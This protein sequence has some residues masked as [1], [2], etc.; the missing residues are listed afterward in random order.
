MA[1]IDDKIEYKFDIA[2]QHLLESKFIDYDY[3]IDKVASWETEL[4]LNKETFNNTTTSGYIIAKNAFSES[5]TE[6]VN[7]SVLLNSISTLKHSDKCHEYFNDEDERRLHNFQENYVDGSSR[8]LVRWK[9]EQSL[10]TYDDGFGLMVI[11]TIGLIYPSGD[12]SGFFPKYPSSLPDYSGITGEKFFARTFGNN[13]DDKI[14]KFGGIF[15]ITGLTKEQFLNCNLSIIIS[16]D[17]SRWYSLKHVRGENV[18]VSTGEGNSSIS[19]TGVLTKLE[20]NDGKLQVSWM[21]PG[22]TS[23]INL[24]YFKLGMNKNL[25]H[26][27]FCIKSISLLNSDGTEEW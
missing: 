20:E 3:S 19:A 5:N 27:K 13:N 26:E 9:S 14:R 12:W 22:T 7:V 24:L 16:P 1:A 6:I 10:L 17:K 15:E 8:G 21:Y 4:Y 25:K 23:S 2:D 18:A 11:P